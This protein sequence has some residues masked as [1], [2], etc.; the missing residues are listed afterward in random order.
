MLSPSS[1]NELHWQLMVKKDMEVAVIKD[2]I[3]K[4]GSTNV[5]ITCGEM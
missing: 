5:S 1:Q 4:F 3:L 2:L